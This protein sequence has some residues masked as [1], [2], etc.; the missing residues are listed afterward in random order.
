M[1]RQNYNY[2]VIASGLLAYNVVHHVDVCQCLP[3]FAAKRDKLDFE[4]LDKHY[5]SFF[6]YFC[7]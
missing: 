6:V 1:E 3:M 5:L 2:I 4:H 7:A